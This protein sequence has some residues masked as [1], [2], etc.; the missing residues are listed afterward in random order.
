[1]LPSVGD[2]DGNDVPDV[3]FV[4]GSSVPEDNSAAYLGYVISGETPS[5]SAFQSV[6]ATVDDGV[7]DTLPLLRFIGDVDA[8]GRDDLAGFGLFVGLDTLSDVI[9]PT[10]AAFIDVEVFNAYRCDLDSNGQSD[11]CANGRATLGPVDVAPVP[12]IV[13][14]GP[15]SLPPPHSFE[16]LHGWPEGFVAASKDFNDQ[17]DLFAVDFDV[18]FDQGICPAN[19]SRSWVVPADTQPIVITAELTGDGTTDVAIAISTPDGADS[20]IYVFSEPPVS[21]TDVRDAPIHLDVPFPTMPGSLHHADLDGD[22]Q[23]DLVYVSNGHLMVHRGPVLAGSTP[24]DAAAGLF[25]NDA[26]SPRIGLNDIYDVDGDGQQ[27]LL[28]SDPADELAGLNAGKLYVVWSGGIGSNS[29]D[30]PL[31]AGLED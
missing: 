25:H 31:P 19:A 20:G 21:G 22:G 17:V 13:H 3:L 5:G 27:D 28:L 12:D 26:N 14:C 24:V 2:V 9:E 30:E 7:P 1:M 15:P 11:L 10:N 4:A 29:R 23:D 6:L 8:D 18:A 16:V